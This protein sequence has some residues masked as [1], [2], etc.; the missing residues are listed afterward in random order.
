MGIE[1]IAQLTLAH[2]KAL[3]RTRISLVLKLIAFMVFNP[4]KMKGNNTYAIDRPILNF[5]DK[6][7]RYK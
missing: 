4:R 5:N 7:I 3:A 6:T 1:G 2:K